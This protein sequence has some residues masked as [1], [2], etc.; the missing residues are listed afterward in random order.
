[1]DTYIPFDE[2]PLLTEEEK[3]RILSDRLNRLRTV[4]DSDF[5]KNL[6][7]KLVGSVITNITTIDTEMSQVS[8][9]YDNGIFLFIEV[10]K[11]D[12]TKDGFSLIGPRVAR[13]D[14]TELRDNVDFDVNSY[15]ETWALTESPIYEDED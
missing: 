15:E 3:A 2:M 11:P 1:M 5:I 13:R 12:G 10:K 6:S 14:E 9:R 4:K 7:K 8:N